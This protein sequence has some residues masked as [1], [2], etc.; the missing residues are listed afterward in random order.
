MVGSLSNGSGGSIVRLHLRNAC[1]TVVA[2]SRL[3]VEAI[4]NVIPTNFIYCLKL[5]CYIR[6]VKE[7]Y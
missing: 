7:K 1:T 4:N 6:V 3:G 5:L 2:P